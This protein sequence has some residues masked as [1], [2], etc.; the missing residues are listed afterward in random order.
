MSATRT[1]SV[2]FV[3]GAEHVFCT[4]LKH[5]NNGKVAYIG[6]NLRM[7]CVPKVQGH[8]YR[9]IWSVEFGDPAHASQSGICAV[10]RA[11]LFPSWRQ[12]AGSRWEETPALFKVRGIASVY[13]SHFS[14]LNDIEMG[15]CV[16]QE[17]IRVLTAIFLRQRHFLKWRFFVSFWMTNF[18]HVKVMRHLISFPAHWKIFCLIVVQFAFRPTTFLRIKKLN[19]VSQPYSVSKYYLAHKLLYKKYWALTIL[20]YVDM[21]HVYVI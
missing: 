5:W 8:H 20:Y 6:K 15:L 18:V 4:R 1:V 16:L 7:L 19:P 14:Q 3:F 17:R 12:T 9:T 10:S 11:S 21:L 2:T 13:C